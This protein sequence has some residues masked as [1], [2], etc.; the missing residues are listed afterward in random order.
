MILEENENQIFTVREV[1]SEDTLLSIAT[2]VGMST[3]HLIDFHNLHCEKV[4]L[5]WLN[6]LVGRDKILIPKNYK[7][8]EQILSERKDALPKP[9]FS[10]K[11]Y[12]DSYQVQETFD[13]DLVIAYQVELKSE[14]EKNTL[15]LSKSNF[16]KNNISPDDK[17]SDIA[18]ACS[19]IMEPVLLKFNNEGLP[20]EIENHKQLKNDF[21]KQRTEL[22]G[23]YSGEVYKAYLDEFENKIVNPAQLLAKLRAT[24]LYQILFPN[25]KWFDRSKP[26]NEDFFFVQN[27]FSL[28]C[29][30][31]VEYHLDFSTS[32]ETIIQA[33]NVENISLLELLKAVKYEGDE[34]EEPAKLDLKIT[35]RTNKTT[36]LLESAS[37]E[38]RFW[39]EGELY[40]EHKLNIVKN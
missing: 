34:P 25:K 20:N 14:K 10:Q 23:I 8:P 5:I 11:F 2:S 33:E 15:Q 17:M 32:A 24:L 19:Q 22:E 40:K 4:G 39:Q 38:L 21:E 35:Y 36:K 9:V 12:A 7:S 30:F 13:N 28:K 37:A 1:Q 27:S 18:L 16:K 6:S 26:W 29:L 31:N 3:E